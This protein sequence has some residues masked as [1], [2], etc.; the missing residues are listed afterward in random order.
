MKQKGLISPARKI[1][2]I[3]TTGPTLPEEVGI[4]LIVNAIGTRNNNESGQQPAL[5][6]FK[7]RIKEKNTR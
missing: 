6:I 7:F 4:I 3:I 5:T 2:N 1:E